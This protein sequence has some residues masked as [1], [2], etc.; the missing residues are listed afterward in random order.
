MHK[1]ILVLGLGKTGFSIARYMQHMGKNFAIYDTRLNPPDLDKFKQA[2]P[3]I[4]VYCQAY[5]DALL[6]SVEKIICSP[7]VSPSESIM[8]K[9]LER[10]IP[11]E[12]ELDC[13]ADEI[14]V[15]VIAITGSNGKSTVTTLVGEM[16]KRAGLKVAVGG[17]LG[18]PVL[19]MLLDAHDYDL[20][21][22]ELSSFQLNFMHR[23]RIKAATILN[24]SPDHLDWHGSMDN[25][26][27]AKHQIYKHAEYVIFNRD[28]MHTYP[29]NVT[30]I[31]Q[32]FG[33]SI[34]V[35]D[36]EW[37]LSNMDL[38]QGHEVWISVRDLKL[39]GQHN[40]MNVLAAMGLA[41]AAAIEKKAII[42]VLKSFSG[43]SHRTQWAGAINGIVFIND[44][45]GTNLGAT[46]A[47]IEG[48]GPTI[49]GKLIL[50]AGGLGKGADFSPLRE[51]LQHYVKKVI[52]IGKDADL[53]A[54][55]W[56]GAAL[57]QKVAS[58]Q[59][60]V[61]EAHASATAGD[62]V[63]LSPAC[64]SFDMFKGYEHRGEEFVKYVREL[65]T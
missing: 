14:S 15:P 25:Y 20:W 64:A 53:L 17:N 6:D 19:D 63:L 22:L 2:F 59:Q 18:T 13:L 56:E 57:L 47:A 52:L 54:Q 21:V 39:Q 24:I 38:M 41:H 62:L 11:I 9:A 50:I 35:S 29:H 7:G 3:N 16:A 55:Y 42:D 45:K 43:L 60:A 48:I 44:S 27:A 12:S 51:T 46:Q 65:M 1:M 40:W 26:I 61:I 4:A 28:D 34:P 31:S 37:G 8:Q 33:L 23:L 36:T 32:S 49:S 5:E 58:L 30:G 10:H